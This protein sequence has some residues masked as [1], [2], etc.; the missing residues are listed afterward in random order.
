VERSAQSMRA[1]GAPVL[2]ERNKTRAE[3]A[4]KKV[5]E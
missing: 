3:A 2:R 4:K 5:K 1:G